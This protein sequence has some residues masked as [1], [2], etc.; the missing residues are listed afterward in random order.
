MVKKIVPVA[1]PEPEI[2]A[3]RTLMTNQARE[4]F[5]QGR[6]PASL[7][8]VLIVSNVN[9]MVK[10]LVVPAAPRMNLTSSAAS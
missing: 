6:F 7:I 1:A 8:D 5:R 2:T 3:L 9:R 4:V 10:I